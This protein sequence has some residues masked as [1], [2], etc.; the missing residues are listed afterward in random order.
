MAYG[1]NTS[2]IFVN[3]VLLGQSH[4]YLIT[5]L[6]SMTSFMLQWQKKKIFGTK[7]TEPKILKT[8]PVQEKV[9]QP[10]YRRLLKHM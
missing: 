9:C 6:L 1:P 5:F 7:T 8:G 10:R 2:L 4:V 3:K